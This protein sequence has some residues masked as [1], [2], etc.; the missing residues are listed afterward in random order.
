MS[1]FPTHPIAAGILLGLVVPA[2]VHCAEPADPDANLTVIVFN[3]AAV[4]H[5]RACRSPR[6]YPEMGRS[7]T[8][9]DLVSS[10]RGEP[11][12]VSWLGAGRFGV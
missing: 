9:T 7:G 10:S 12:F 1:R 4:P 6:V 5:R 3:Y 8:A 2:V 11:A